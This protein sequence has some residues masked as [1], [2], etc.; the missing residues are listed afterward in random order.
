[1]ACVASLDMSSSK[2]LWLTSREDKERS[3]GL[4]PMAGLFII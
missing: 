4:P 2:S 1:M 3:F